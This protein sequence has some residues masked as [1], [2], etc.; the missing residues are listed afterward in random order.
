METLFS[1]FW[2]SGIFQHAYAVSKKNSNKNNS[3]AGNFFITCRRSDQDGCWLAEPKRWFCCRIRRYEPPP[4]AHIYQCSRL[5][6]DVLHRTCL[7]TLR[8]YHSTSPIVSVKVCK[9]SF[10]KCRGGIYSSSSA[11]VLVVVV[12]DGAA[13]VESPERASVGGIQ[14]HPVTQNVPDTHV[15]ESNG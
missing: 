1:W 4:L 14:H 6:V 12:V 11:E 13:V 10:K 7:H 3:F 8:S 5:I 2:L 9:I 15:Q